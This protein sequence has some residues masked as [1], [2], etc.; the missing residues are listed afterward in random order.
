MYCIH[1]YRP[2]QT[3]SFNLH[4]TCSCP[5]PARHVKQLPHILQ[6]TTSLLLPGENACV[7]PE[8]GPSI[9][10]P[11]ARISLSQPP[12]SV[13]SLP[14]C[15]QLA[16]IHRCLVLP[17]TLPTPVLGHADLCLLPP[18]APCTCKR[19]SE[20]KSGKMT[21]RA[22]VAGHSPPVE[23]PSL[24][25]MRNSHHSS[26]FA[27][28][29]SGACTA[30]A[31]SPSCTTQ[32]PHASSPHETVQIHIRTRTSTCT[33]RYVPKTRRLRPHG[34]GGIGVCVHIYLDVS[35]RLLESVSTHVHS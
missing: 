2:T 12:C 25:S 13:V 22:E 26:Y 31:A 30:P 29:K 6:R 34:H 21:A 1:V 9:K 14:S 10:S 3:R 17:I 23:A 8:L 27:T 18:S 35:L 15:R 33:C 16:D 4:D 11:S 28:G 7:S 20:R 19:Q 32:T 5:A 24:L